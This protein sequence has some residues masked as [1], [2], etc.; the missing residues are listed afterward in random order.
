MKQLSKELYILLF[1]GSSLTF[2]IISSSMIHSGEK[3]NPI[4]LVGLVFY[5]LRYFVILFLIYQM[6][7]SIQDMYARTTPGK[8]I[9]FLFIPIYNFYWLHQMLVGFVD[10][11]NS[12][13]S[14]NEINKPELQSKMFVMYFFIYINT[15]VPIVGTFAYLAS[16]IVGSIMISEICDAV[17]AVNLVLSVRTKEL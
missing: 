12:F 11:Y 7:S 1:V 15:F 6:W 10:D 5:A 8:A 14:R 16:I 3:E 17:N 2:V 13:I 9:G 4:F